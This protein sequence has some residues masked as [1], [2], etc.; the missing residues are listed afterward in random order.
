MAKSK[1]EDIFVGLDIGSSKICTVVGVPEG[2]DSVRVIGLGV[3]NTTGLRKGLVSEVEETVSGIS[4]SIEIAERMAGISIDRAVV[5]INGAHINSVNSRGVIAVGRADHE[6]TSDDLIRVEDAAQAVQIPS[7][8]EVLHVLPRSYSVD[9]QED[10]K[11]PVGMNGVRLE[12][13]THLVT[14]SQPI[15]RNLTK[16]VTQAG[17]G[18]EDLIISPLAAS[19]P[20]LSKRQ[21]ELGSVV[22]DI[23][24]GTMGICVFEDGSVLHSTILPIGAGHITNDIAI[25]L[26]TSIDI[27]EKVKVKH[28]DANHKK[29]SAK[30][31][32]DLSQI[33]IKEEGEI[34]KKDISEIIEARLFEMFKMVRDELKKINRDGLLPAGAVLVGGGARL[35]NICDF[36]KDVLKIPVTIGLPRDI[37]GVIDKVNDPFYAASL[38]LM[39]YSFEDKAQP[40]MGRQLGEAVERIKRIFKSFL[41]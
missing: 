20:V 16:C 13:E 39:L 24:A 9:G 40:G 11:D 29:V 18:M 21:M 27:A 28:G 5:N 6:I 22:I 25:G 38:G 2:E 17:I 12:V 8:R 1:K 41:P 15:V 31:K 37:R 30:E 23:G 35:A 34:L 26:R 10:I 32:I 4:E 7:N 19:R 3:S 33:D 14:I 36:A